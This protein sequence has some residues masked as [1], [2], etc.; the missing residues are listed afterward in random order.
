MLFYDLGWENRKKQTTLSSRNFTALNK[1]IWHSQQKSTIVSTLAY[2]QRTHANPSIYFLCL[3]TNST[4]LGI[5][6]IFITKYS[7]RS[8]YITYSSSAIIQFVGWRLAERL[9]SDI[10]SIQHEN[11][12]N[13]ICWQNM[14]VMYLTTIPFIWT[15][16][17]K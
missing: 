4:L 11:N 3:L 6:E 16:P 8:N 14:S 5:S 13:K 12:W 15:D 10:L 17:L 9:T 7:H 1:L 2:S